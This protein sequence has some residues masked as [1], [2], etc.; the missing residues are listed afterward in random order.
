MPEELLFCD[1]I[2]DNASS[3]TYR[4]ADIYVGIVEIEHNTKNEIFRKSMLEKLLLPPSPNNM[5]YVQ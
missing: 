3:I 1:K 4:I 5:V 2:L